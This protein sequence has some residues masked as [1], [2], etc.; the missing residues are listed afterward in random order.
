MDSRVQGFDSSAENFRRPGIVSNLGDREI[1]FTQQFG[2]PTGREQC[3]AEITQSFGEFD[4]SGFIVDGKNS[5][6]H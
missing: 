4:K 1:I 3:P 6:G 5:S 2:C